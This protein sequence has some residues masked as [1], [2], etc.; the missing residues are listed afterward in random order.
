[1]DWLVIIGL[2]AG[3]FYWR[4]EYNKAQKKKQEYQI[5][6]R[7]IFDSLKKSHLYQTLHHDRRAHLDEL[8]NDQIF[9]TLT[10]YLE[11]PGAYLGMEHPEPYS[12]T[13]NTFGFGVK[14][15]E[16]QRTTHLYIIGKTGSGKTTL[17]RNLIA[18]DLDQGAGLAVISP[19]AEFITEEILPHVPEHRRAD[20]IYI[21]PLD[22]ERPV[23]FN[24]LHR[25]RNTRDDFDRQI[26]ETLSIFSR[27]IG[28][29]TSPGRMERIVSNAFQALIERPGSTLLDIERLLDPADPTLRAEI[30]KRTRDPQLRD[31]FE[32]VYPAYPKDAHLPITNR[33]SKLIRPKRVRTF[34]CHPHKSLN[35]RKVM[36]AG[37]I[38]L[39]NLSDGLLGTETASV[40]G[41]LVISKIQATAVARADQPAG[42]RRRFYLYIDEFHA[43]TGVASRSYE[44]ML[45][46][47]RKYELGLILAHQQTGQI[48]QSLL[49]EI[50]GNVG[51]IVCLEVAPDDARK[52]THYFLLADGTHPKPE[53]LTQLTQGNA[54][55]R[56]GQ[57]SFP[58]RLDPPP[59]TRHSEPADLIA[60]SRNHWGRPFNETETHSRTKQPTHDEDE[61]DFTATYDEPN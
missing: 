14:I 44:V 58:L 29:S 52:F 12:R 13:E 35:F 6:R 55:A 16:R 22:T 30:C 18:Q 39:F 51:A 40:I 49:R 5:R 4:Y 36:D 46:R 54:F 8:P 23:P 10:T 41:E 33:V 11:D 38:L 37:K 56:I 7:H 28:D 26:D 45:S 53:Q 57:T 32:R 31:F 42:S 3:A 20:V 59:S 48:P 9:P 2:L 43:F 25:H 47:A 19:E 1:M 24:P 34:L 50:L 60:S 15:P 17:L 21:N 61:D 27:F